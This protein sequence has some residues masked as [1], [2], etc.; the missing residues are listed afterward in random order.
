MAHQFMRELSKIAKSISFFHLLPYII[1]VKIFRES[2]EIKAGNLC[3]TPE[4][5]NPSQC[6]STLLI[7]SSLENPCHLTQSAAASRNA[8]WISVTQ[9][10][11]CRSVQYRDSAEFSRPELISDD[12]KDSRNV[13]CGQSPCLSAVQIEN[14]AHHETENQTTTT[15]DFWVSKI[16]LAKL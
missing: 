11:S 10:G 16:P 3:W 1:I 6:Y 8:N 12:L 9:G 2:R 5:S 15:T 4:P 14:K 7:G 13:W